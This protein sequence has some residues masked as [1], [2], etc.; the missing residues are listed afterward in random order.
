MQNIV[1]VAHTKEKDLKRARFSILNLQYFAPEIELKH[2]IIVYTDAPSYFSDLDVLI[3]EMDNITISMW[4]GCR[5]S[6]ERVRI[7]AARDAFAT[8]H[9]TIILVGNEV[10][11]LDNPSSIFLEISAGSS[12]MYEEVAPFADMG[13]KLPETINYLAIEPYQKALQK[14]LPAPPPH[15]AIYNSAI[16][17]IHES[18]KGMIKKVLCYFDALMSHLPE[19][20]STAVAFSYVLGTSTIL[21]EAN[22]WIDVYDKAYRP[23]NG[24]L[25]TFFKENDGLPVKTQQVEAWRLAHQFDGSAKYSKTDILSLVREINH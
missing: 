7:L 22:D 24:L 23:I 13:R 17:G 1:Y 16:I 9:G 12:M 20:I 2:R 4:Q 19:S 6:N 3:E 21:Q 14:S 11:Y 8:Y 15:I 5:N 25:N 10:F 18:D